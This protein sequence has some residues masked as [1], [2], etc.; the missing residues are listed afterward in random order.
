MTEKEVKI[1]KLLR[2]KSLTYNEL[3][4]ILKVSDGLLK[5]YLNELY[6]NGYDIQRRYYSDGGIELILSG[7]P[8]DDK[9]QK[10]KDSKQIPIIIPSE[11]NTFKAL[12]ISDLHFGCTKARLDLVNIVFNY[13]TACGIHTIFGCGDMIDGD[14]YHSA[15]KSIIGDIHKQI[16]YFINKF[17]YDKNIL[18]FAVLGNH[19]ELASKKNLV[20]IKR[21]IN[22][23]RSD[24]IVGNYDG[25]EIPI[26]NE[27]IRLEHNTLEKFKKRKINIFGHAHKYKAT[28][29]SDELNPLERYISILTPA[30]SDV[31]HGKPSFLEMEL[32]FENGKIIEVILREI[33][34]DK[35]NTMDTNP[36]ETYYRFPD[37]PDE[38]EE[39]LDQKK[40]IKTKRKIIK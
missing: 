6:I 17:P 20:D 30:L 40:N 16:E 9:K 35:N 39:M 21:A 18:T 1:I 2:E 29:N 37:I 28:L 15:G 3:A 11:Q 19:E 22:N 14:P 25:F 33:G 36:M 38:D 32:N 4:N 13:A 31:N 8:V 23:N 5:K 34:F 7:I 24:I 26:K 12:I 10:D 27:I